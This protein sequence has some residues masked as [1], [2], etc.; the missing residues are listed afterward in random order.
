MSEECKYDGLRRKPT[1]D[2]LITSI[3]RDK[4]KITLPNRKAFILAN[5]RQMNALKGDTITDL[6]EM[7]TRLEKDK[8]RNLLISEY[9]SGH[10]VSIAEASAVIPPSRPPQQFDIV[11]EPSLEAGTTYEDIIHEYRQHQID[12]AEAFNQFR[13]NLEQHQGMRERGAGVSRFLDSVPSSNASSSASSSNPT[14]SFHPEDGLVDFEGVWVHNPES[15]HARRQANAE[16][17]VDALPQTR[18]RPQTSPRAQL[19][20]TTT[21]NDTPPS[22]MEGPVEPPT[23]MKPFGYDSSRN[24]GHWKE[25]TQGYILWQLRLIGYHIDKQRANRMSKEEL[26]NILFQQ[27]EITPPETTID[28]LTERYRNLSIGHTGRI[29]NMHPTSRVHESA[30]ANFVYPKVPKT[31]EDLKPQ[32]RMPRRQRKQEPRRRRSRSPSNLRLSNVLDTSAPLFS[33]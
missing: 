12:V 4:P 6:Q 17:F 19:I 30:A 3:Q 10:H 22:T 15:G 23:T 29:P 24:P 1:F 27:K 13:R 14:I 32:A 20:H 9:A 5:T 31:Q 28:E 21:T 33:I 11:S 8:L 7:E 16:L 2:E 18:P 25:Q 26:L